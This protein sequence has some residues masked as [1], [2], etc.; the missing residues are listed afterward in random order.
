MH[1]QGWYQIAFS[2]E[3]SSTVSPAVVGSHRLVVLQG[4]GGIRIADALCPHRGANLGHGGRLEGNAIIC[5]FHGFRIGLGAAAEHG[6]R[7]REHDALAVGDLVFVRLWDGPDNGFSTLMR[8]LSEKRIIRPGFKLRLRAAAEM[9]IENAFDQAHFRP[10]HGIGLDGGFE[11]LPSEA[12]ELSVSGSF[13]LPPSPWQRGQ[14][15]TGAGFI[16]FR[17]QAF[18]PGIVVSDLG[19]AYPYTVLTAATPVPEGGCVVRLSLALERDADRAPYP[20]LVDFLLRRSREGLERDRV[21][22][23]HRSDELPPTYTPFDGPV[24]AFREFC[25]SFEAGAEP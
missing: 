9:V 17:A 13:D 22:W 4:P 12:G 1:R 23:E 19:G 3:L 16:P 14:P 18:S 11:L 2:N 10:V 6:L 21:V 24:R 15:G 20:A 25:A 5:P 7:V 8:S